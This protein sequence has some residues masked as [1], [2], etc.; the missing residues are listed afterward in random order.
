MKRTLIGIAICATLMAS[1]PAL[2]QD[3]EEVPS[4]QG[5]DFS[6]DPALSEDPNAIVVPELSAAERQAAIAAARGPE[7]AKAS[8]AE[9]RGLDKVT[10]QLLDFHLAAGEMAEFGRLQVT[11]GECRFPAKDPEA[12][13]YAELTVFD[14]RVNQTVFSGWMIASAPALSAMDDPRYDV[15]VMSC[16][17]S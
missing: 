17:K 4:V 2:A 14:K 16:S 5:E 7:T 15:W 3:E 10:G 9:L 13:A 6:M 1:N 11:L 12:D 8:G